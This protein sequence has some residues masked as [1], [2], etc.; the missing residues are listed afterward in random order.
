[1][2]PYLALIVDNS[3]PHIQLAGYRQSSSVI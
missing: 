3:F 1:M 2:L